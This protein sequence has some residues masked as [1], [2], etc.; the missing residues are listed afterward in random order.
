MGRTKIHRLDRIE[1]TFPG[2]LY[3]ADCGTER[4]IN[5]GV[6]VESGDFD[7]LNMNPPEFRPNLCKPC[8]GDAAT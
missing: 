5:R 3:V 7:R 8:L 6:M 2:Y 4:V 1:Q